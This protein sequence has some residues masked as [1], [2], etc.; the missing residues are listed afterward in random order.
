MAEQY[1]GDVRGRSCNFSY[2]LHLVKDI[3]KAASLTFVQCWKTYSYEYPSLYPLYT[4][5]TIVA[6]NVITSGVKLPHVTAIV[7]YK[8][9]LREEIPLISKWC[10]IKSKR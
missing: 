6:G 8:K 10:T 5:A 9:H 2:I 4:E 1:W 7:Y 3:E